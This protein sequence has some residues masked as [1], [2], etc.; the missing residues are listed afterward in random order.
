MERASDDGVDMGL[1]RPIIDVDLAA[2]KILFLRL[3]EN[4][5][6]V[7]FYNLVPQYRQI[8]QIAHRLRMIGDE[9]DAD[10]RIKRYKLTLQF[11]P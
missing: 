2:R 8:Q 1:V 5:Y 3:V 9:L 10:Q 11:C 6:E 7:V 4:S